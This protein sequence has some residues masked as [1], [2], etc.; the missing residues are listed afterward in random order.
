[1]SRLETCQSEAFRK[2]CSERMKARHKLGLAP[3]FKNRRI[4]RTFIS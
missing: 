4:I 1:M 2:A 3:T